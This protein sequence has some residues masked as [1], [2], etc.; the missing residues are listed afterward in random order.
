MVDSTT[1]QRQRN[2]ENDRQWSGLADRPPSGLFSA[3]R[4]R[5]EARNDVE[6]FLV[7]AALTQAMEVAV[8]VLQQFIDV[9]IGALHG[10]QA[11]GVLAG[12]R[13]SARPEQRHE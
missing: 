2:C 7:D 12:Q 8:E 5:F 11:A 3:S 6:Q 4:Q 9:L 13:F 10:S 1:P